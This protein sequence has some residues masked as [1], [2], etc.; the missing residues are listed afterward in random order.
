MHS[1][2]ASM[3]YSKQ[4]VIIVTFWRAFMTNQKEWVRWIQLPSQNRM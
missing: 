1:A 4:H 2:F 3:F